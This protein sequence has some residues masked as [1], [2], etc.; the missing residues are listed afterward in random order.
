M[1][2]NKTQAELYREE[3]KARLQKAAAKKA[4]KS[5]VS[6]KA[7]KMATKIIAIVLAVVIGLGAIYATLDFFGVPQKVVKI[8]VDETDYSFS[9]AE[10]NFYYYTMVMNYT[11]TAYQYDA[12]YG[13]GSGLTYLGYE[14][15]KTPD[16]QSYTD[17][18]SSMTGYTLEDIGNPKNA[19]W[20]DVFK[21][22]TIEQILQVK[23][24]VEKA[25]EMGI[26]L[27]EDEQASISES[28][29]SLR[30][31]AKSNDY[32]LDRYLR[33]NYGNG[34]TEKL[35]TRIYEEQTLATNYFTQLETDTLAA[36]TDEEVNSTYNE[37]KQDYDLVDLRIYGIA[38]E[39]DAADDATSEEKAAAEEKAD[40]EA[41]S[42]ANAMLSEI[43][44]EASFLS[45]VELD[46]KVN[47]PD[48]E[49]YDADQ[50][51]AATGVAYANLANAS[52]D[53]ADWAYNSERQAGDKTIIKTDDYYYL[54]LVVKLPYKD[55]TI[56]SN[57]VRHILVM[58]PEEN[59]DGTSTTVTD[60]DGNETTNITDETK[61]ATKA[62][63]DAILEEYKKNPTEENFIALAKEKSEDTS[64]EN[65]GLI[66]GVAD[67]GTYVEAFTDWS[68][69]TA[70]KTGD[71]GVIETEYGYHV[72][73]YV[74]AG[75][76]TWFQTVKDAIF[77]EKYT[78]VTTDALEE[79][80]KNIDADSVLI[81]MVTKDQNKLIGNIILYNFV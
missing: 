21:Y 61:A 65:G 15:T 43:T 24:A 62:K 49:D 54:A 71:T 32:S 69:D 40:A 12:Y 17:D 6:E 51:T 67:D 27:T 57:D 50:A 74:A 58:F 44:D 79:V 63:A 25:A 68:I 33:A 64:A 38:I 2:N 3:R 41:K 7:K 73:Y 39:S 29:E 18:Y 78:A 1:E 76:Q 70:R 34:I 4:K 36:I 60:D 22:A 52:E 46:L 28:I 20:E 26:E 11:Q 59:T 81:K 72:M 56:V 23:Y 9:L 10:Y 53:L 19:T 80:Y 66:E 77:S 37:N 30:T 14:Y 35:V 45:Q 31:S 55:T 5:P 48:E 47:E 8:S 13:A 75:E 16:K 42:R